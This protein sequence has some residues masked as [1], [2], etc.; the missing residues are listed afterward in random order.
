LTSPSAGSIAAPGRPAAAQRW[1]RCSR[2]STAGSIAAPTSG[3]KSRTGPWCSRP[4]NGGL[5]C[6]RKPPIVLSAASQVLPPSSGGLHCGGDF[7]VFDPFEIAGAPA[8]Q[9]RAPLRRFE[10]QADQWVR[11]VCSRRSTAG[12]N[13]ATSMSERH[14]EKLQWSCQSSERER[15]GG[16]SEAG[17][18]SHAGQRTFCTLTSPSSAVH[19]PV[20]L[21]RSYVDLFAQIRRRSFCELCSR[22]SAAGSIA[23]TAGTRRPPRSSACSRRS[24]AGSI[25]AAT[26]TCQPAVDGGFRLFN[27][28]PRTA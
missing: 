13:V 1:R 14:H 25:A 27:R 10:L 9:R 11:P 28:H 5:H 4:I 16:D 8:V 26:P 22:R 7:D 2:R 19:S 18:R 6:G 24:A 21:D 23:A 17:E 15:Q 12:S 20:N 3:A